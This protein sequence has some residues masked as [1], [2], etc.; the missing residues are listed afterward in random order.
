MEKDFK[1]TKTT[2]FN[3]YI[4]D[5][6]N[7]ASFNIYTF[8][9]KQM[10]IFT[11][12]DSLKNFVEDKKLSDRFIQQ[13]DRYILHTIEEV[14]EVLDVS[15]GFTYN[16]SKCVEELID[17]LMYTGTMGGI[18][19]A[20]L[21]KIRGEDV[22]KDITIPIVTTKYN[23]DNEIKEGLLKGVLLEVI[24]Y[25]I[26]IRRLFPE[27]KWHKPHPECDV[28]TQIER[29]E[30]ALNLIKGI[31]CMI[32]NTVLRVKTMEEIENQILDKN[33]FIQSLPKEA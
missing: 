16:K 15:S 24:S 23:K 10:E 1:R 7:A 14:V 33:G 4:D 18:I 8:F 13:L 3:H 30:K 9:R 27:R 31:C 6:I 32:L 11:K 12:Y 5:E 25:L 22:P 19:D 26:E 29:L 2:F 20:S 28:E 17:V 21:Y